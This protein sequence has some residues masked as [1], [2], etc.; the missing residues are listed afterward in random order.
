MKREASALLCPDTPGGPALTP[1]AGPAPARA[2]GARCGP[3]VLVGVLGRGGM[4]TVYEAV[5]PMLRRRVAVKLLSGGRDGGERLL[6]EARAA[7]R[8][9]HPNVVTVYQAGRAGDEFFIAMQLVRGTSA[10]DAVRARGPLPVRE[11]ARVVLGAA[12]GLA[13]AHALGLVHRDVKPANVLL[14]ADGGVKV[15]DFG[16]ARDC[17]ADAVSGAVGTPEYM[18]PEQAQGL[19]ADPRADLYAL[20]GVWYYLLTGSAPFCGD[21][22]VEVLWKHVHE[23][24]PDPRAL[25]PDVP[26]EWARLVLRCLAKK[27]AER[28]ASAAALIAELERFLAG[29]PGKRARR[30]RTFGLQSAAVVLAGVLGVGAYQHFRAGPPEAPPA[31]GWSEAEA[32]RETSRAGQDEEGQQAPVAPEEKLDHRPAGEEEKPA[33]S[34][35]RPA[36]STP[37]AEETPAPPG[38]PLAPAQRTTQVARTTVLTRTVITPLAKKRP[39]RVKHHRPRR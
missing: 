9:D 37:A 15:A 27:P 11:A 3:F 30:R 29:P 38:P 16:L 5:D 10:A 28:P 22:A 19:P 4:G 2:P 17:A 31:E 6:R 21:S 18:S 39:A 14:A 32:F 36:P 24:A 13:A 34:D 12:R 33:G 35:A 25:R 23:P 8:L 7:A 26:D 20:G 1:G